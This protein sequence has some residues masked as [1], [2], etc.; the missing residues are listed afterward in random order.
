MLFQFLKMVSWLNFKKRFLYLPLIFAFGF[1]ADQ[2]A[3]KW[4]FYG[5]QTI[6]GMAI[7]TLPPELFG[8]Y[9]TNRDFIS[10]HAIDPDKRRYAIQEEAARHYIDLDRYYSFGEDPLVN[11]PTYWNEAI[12]KF[13]LDTLNSYGIVPWYIVTMKNKLQ[14]AFEQKNLDLILIYSADIGHYIA[15]AHVPLHT[16]KNYNGQLT[17]QKGIHGLWESRLVELHVG[18]YDFFTGKAIYIP[19]VQQRIWQVVRDSHLALDSVFRFEKETS[20]AI[21]ES[22]KYTVET[23]GNQHI[24]TYSKAFSDHY[25]HL[26]NGM[27]ERRM[28]QAVQLV[29]AVWYTAWIDAGQPNLTDLLDKKIKPET[30]EQLTQFHRET[31]HNHTQGRACE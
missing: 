1:S 4:G 5:H 31:L 23:R 19:N 17:N 30:M 20:E 12:E 24:Q 29:G 27:V 9:K 21:P 22:L 3:P 16:T 26:L 7:F 15:D 13:S 18:S 6:N 28:R 25:H 8:F 10:D 2:M 11:L 14:W